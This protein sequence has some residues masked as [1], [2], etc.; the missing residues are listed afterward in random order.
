MVVDL[1]EV[2]LGLKKVLAFLNGVVI[3]FTQEVLLEEDDDV[4]VAILSVFFLKKIL[5]V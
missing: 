4:E 5:W 3:V 2:P 1:V